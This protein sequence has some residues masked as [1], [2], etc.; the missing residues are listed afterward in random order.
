[1][2]EREDI[3]R[4]I[5]N[6]FRSHFLLNID[7]L[8]IR[9]EKEKFIGVICNQE[10]V[11]ESI[12]REKTTCIILS[13]PLDPRQITAGDKELL[14]TKVKYTPENQ[15]IIVCFHEEFCLLL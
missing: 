8:F 7:T 5:H 15:Y 11:R 9:R 1:M 6:Q 2:V 4:R 13:L 12:L 3:C 14:K 10:K